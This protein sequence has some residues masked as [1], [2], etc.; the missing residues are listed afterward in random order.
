MMV[1]AAAHPLDRPVWAAL[2]SGWRALAVGADGGWRLAADLGPFAATAAGDAEA[3]ARWLPRDR[4][5]WFV[6]GAAVAAPPGFAVSLVRELTQMVADQVPPPAAAPAFVP[7]G[8][9]DV[10][11]MQALAALTSPGP[12]LPRT[13]ELGGFVGYREGGR[14]LAMAG[15]RMRLPGF[16]EVSGVCTHPD[17]RGRG[18]AAQASM[19]V[20]GAIIAGGAQPFLHAYPDNVP[21]INLYRALG[22]VERTRLVLTVISPV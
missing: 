3:V 6:E 8:A 20:A 1:K 14:L 17:A 13:H 22:F 11:A 19:Q 21:A 15:T 9:A 12:F 2:T 16:V 18:L 5:S 10:E 7:L 4:D